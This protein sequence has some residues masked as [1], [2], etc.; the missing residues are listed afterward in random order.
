MGIIF[1]MLLRSMLFSVIG[2]TFYKWFTGT[3]WGVW[4]D[5][6]VQITLNKVIGKH[7][8]AVAKKSPQIDMFDNDKSS[9][10]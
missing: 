1:W 6:K 3:T 5:Y 4:I 7:N 2:N 10:S 8:E 9:K